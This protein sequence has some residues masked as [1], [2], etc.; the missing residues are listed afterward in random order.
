L[1]PARWH[2]FVW[3]VRLVKV[4]VTGLTTCGLA[5]VW[6]AFYL[7][8]ERFRRRPRGAMHPPEGDG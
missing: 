4:L 2:L 5:W 1:K 7:Y 8:D 3:I 6:I